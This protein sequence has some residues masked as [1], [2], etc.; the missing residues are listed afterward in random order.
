M[1]T[2]TAFLIG[3]IGGLLVSVFL[4]A[5]REDQPG[6]QRQIERETRKHLDTTHLATKADM[7]RVMRE[8]EELRRAYKDDNLG[9]AEKEF[10]AEISAEPNP[11]NL[12]NI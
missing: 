8:M 7:E 5:G 2:L 6:R 11:P 12:E 3:A 1:D 9:D 4:S 10:Y